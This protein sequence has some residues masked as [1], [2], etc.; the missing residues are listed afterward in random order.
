MGITLGLP[1]LIGD[2]GGNTAGKI[3]E[4]ITKFVEKT[5]FESGDVFNIE[6][7]EAGPDEPK[8][9]YYLRLQVS[10][11]GT[12]EPG[13]ETVELIIGRNGYWEIRPITYNPPKF[14]VS[15]FVMPKRDLRTDW[16]TQVDLLLRAL[17][18]LYTYQAE[19]LDKLANDSLAKAVALSKKVRRLNS[20]IKEKSLIA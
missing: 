6:C 14:P 12:E 8:L 10:P 3:L 18:H 5:G 4:T 15:G 17:N 20:K 16:D 1:I 7:T 11:E 9:R 2:R 13:Y 19:M